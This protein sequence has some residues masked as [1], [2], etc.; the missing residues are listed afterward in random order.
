M[1]VNHILFSTST[2]FGAALSSAVKR[3]ETSFGNLN[4]LHATLAL[5]IDGDGSDAAHFAYMATALGSTNAAAKAAY[6]ELSSFLFK[7][8]T[9]ASVTDVNAALRQ[10]AN[11]LRQG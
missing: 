6:D 1:A 11:K 5:M 7:L 4:E 3:F 2:Q 9:N 10:V 8:N